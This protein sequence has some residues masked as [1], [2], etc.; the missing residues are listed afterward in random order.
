M[1]EASVTPAPVSVKKHESEHNQQVVEDPDTDKLVIPWDKVDQEIDV[2]SFT[3]YTVKLNG[4][5]RHDI[6]GQRKTE[7]DEKEES[8]NEEPADLKE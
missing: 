1:S 6:R 7:I 8:A 4:W 5:I 2:K 3:G